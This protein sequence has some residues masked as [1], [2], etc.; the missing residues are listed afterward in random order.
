M[1]SAKPLEKVTKLQSSA[2]KGASK[3]AQPMSA[4]PAAPGA[5]PASFGLMSDVNLKRTMRDHSEISWHAYAPNNLSSRLQV[6]FSCEIKNNSANVL[7]VDLH[8]IGGQP[9]NDAL[10]LRLRPGSAVTTIEET[11]LGGTRKDVTPQGADFCPVFASAPRLGSGG[12]VTLDVVYT[13]RI[14]A[15]STCKFECFFPKFEPM[16]VAPIRTLELNDGY[17]VPPMPGDLD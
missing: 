14:P 2:L 13:L 12:T 1:S 3:I 9:R 10:K 17:P 8:D 5:P 7:T 11:W 15:N 4:V 16:R 6:W